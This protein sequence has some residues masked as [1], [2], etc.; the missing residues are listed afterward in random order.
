MAGSEMGGNPEFDFGFN[1]D[2]YFDVDV[3]ADRA[4]WELVT[5]KC[6]FNWR[7]LAE[8]DFEDFSLPRRGM[9]GGRIFDVRL[10]ADCNEEIFEDQDGEKDIY[11]SKT[12]GLTV[13]ESIDG[14]PGR[15]LA[16][17][18]ARAAA[19]EMCET[20]DIEK[21]HW[22][23]GYEEAFK[24]K[25]IQSFTFGAEGGVINEASR[26]VRG[27][28]VGEDPVIFPLSQKE[29]S[30]IEELKIKQA[31]LDVIQGACYILKAPPA[32]MKAINEIKQ[33]PVEAI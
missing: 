32:I 12:A 9:Y 21:T 18:L 8:P 14:E 31:D 25:S 24:V 20:D 15:E 19:L 5:A 26:S 4:V 33:R 7:E 6:G 13:A 17:S 29:D 1:P 22:P 3:V 11:V 10:F 16:L 23:C 30:V 2:A 28:M 27:T